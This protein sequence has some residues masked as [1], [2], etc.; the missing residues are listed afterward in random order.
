[1]VPIAGQAPDDD[2][3]EDGDFKDFVAELFVCNTVTGPVTQKLYRKAGRAG[4]EGVP[5]LGKVGNSGKAVG[6]IHR[7]LMRKLMKGCTFP[8]PYWCLVPFLNKETGEEEM[9][10]TPVLL[11]HEVFAWFVEKDPE[12]IALWRP[13]PGH[14]IFYHAE[15]WCEQFD[16]DIMHLIPLGIHGDGVPFAAKMRDTLECISYNILTDKSGARILYTTFPKSFSAGQKTWDALFRVFAWSMRHLMLGLWPRIREDRMGWR[17]NEDFRARMS[18][19]G[20]GFHAAVLQVR[21]DWAFYKETFAFPHWQA[22]QC[23]WKCFARNSPGEVGD[24]RDATSNAAWRNR[25]IS[26][27]EFV[28]LQI[29]EGITPSCLFECPGVSVDMVMVDWLHTMDQGVLAD[30]IG[31]VFWDALPK[32]HQ[33]PRKEQVKVLWQMIQLYYKDARVPDRLD[34]L[35]EEMI[36]DKK[37]AP[38]QRGRAAQVRY[39]LPFAAKLAESFAGEDEHW[40]TVSTVTDGLLQLTLM[41]NIKP[42]DAPRAAHLCQQTVLLLFGL[43]MEALSHGDCFSWRTKPKLHLMEELNVYQT[44]QHGAPC[45]YWTYK[46]ESWG[47]WLA[48]VTARTGGKK[49]AW[50]VALS[51]LMRFRYM[52]HK[53]ETA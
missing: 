47:M 31:N 19:Q 24:F 9:H 30:V 21:G 13:T 39:L 46:D 6:N 27:H 34:S 12:K 20:L 23:C 42:Y 33:P 2:D 43:E 26:G 25:R 4:A 7:D 38:K 22:K 32:I 16:V 3:D 28:A 11:P 44:V 53:L 1:V 36:K 18:G 14:T 10:E 37:K 15:R 50:G 49:T 52:M 51:S 41:N 45:E 40:R 29:A 5:E 48:R 17:K 8:E 35:T